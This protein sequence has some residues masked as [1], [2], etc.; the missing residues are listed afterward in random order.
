MGQFNWVK[1]D[2]PRTKPLIEDALQQA[3]ERAEVHFKEGAPFT[4]A[5]LTTAAHSSCKRF[6]VNASDTYWDDNFSRWDITFMLHY[7]SIYSAEYMRVLELLRSGRWYITADEARETAQAEI[8]AV[9]LEANIVAAVTHPCVGWIVS[10][11]L[12]DRTYPQVFQVVKDAEQEIIID[13]I[14]VVP[15]AD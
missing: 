14:S 11:T 10:F 6:F 4:H 9:D 7:V 3:T 2:H 15:L 12:D 8:A 13:D 5:G 1:E